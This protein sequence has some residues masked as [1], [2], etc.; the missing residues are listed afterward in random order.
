[1]QFE[2]QGE[3]HRL[4]WQ[5]SGASAVWVLLGTVTPREVSRDTEARWQLPPGNQAW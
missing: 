3:M 5:G 2:D 1:M 4:S